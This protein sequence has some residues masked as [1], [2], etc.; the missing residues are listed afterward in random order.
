MMK[1]INENIQAILNLAHQCNVE[2][3]KQQQIECNY[4]NNYYGDQQCQV[5]PN[6]KS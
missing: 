1:N 6:D 4:T 5:M 2:L 3:N